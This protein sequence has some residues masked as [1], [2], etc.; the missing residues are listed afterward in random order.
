MELCTELDSVLRGALASLSPPPS[1]LKICFYVYECLP[2]CITCVPVAL[3]VQEKALEPLEP[4]LQMTVIFH[5][6]AGKQTQVLR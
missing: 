5:V 1:L 4:D 2:M 3:G 6:C